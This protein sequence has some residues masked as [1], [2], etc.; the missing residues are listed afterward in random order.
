MSDFIGS[1]KSCQSPVQE[2]FLRL[3]PSK[4]S[5]DGMLRKQK[6]Y[7]PTPT[8]WS[9]SRSIPIRTDEDRELMTHR[10]THIKILSSPV[11]QETEN[12]P[13]K[14]LAQSKRG[15][16]ASKKKRRGS[17]KVPRPPLIGMGLPWDETAGNSWRGSTEKKGL[18]FRLLRPRAGKKS[19]P[20]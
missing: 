14:L 8:L 3:E 10:L 4:T 19:E 11:R 1:C 12:T 15:K 20:G 7:T 13:Q 5:K 17:R 16:H 6:E 9:L 2:C 18:F